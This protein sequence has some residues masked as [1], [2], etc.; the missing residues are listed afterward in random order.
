ME[1]RF[2][3]SLLSEF[4]ADY[5][6][7]IFALLLQPS[8]RCL[9]ICKEFPTKE[10]LHIHVFVLSAGGQNSGHSM[11]CSWAG[12]CMHMV[13]CLNLKPQFTLQ[14]KLRLLTSE[15][16]FC[17]ACTLLTHMLNSPKAT[18]FKMRVMQMFYI[19]YL[20]LIPNFPLTHGRVCAQAKGH[21]WPTYISTSKFNRS[22]ILLVPF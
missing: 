11:F 6:N 18:L 1:S 13:V 2:Q 19:Y 14:L 21:L 20:S 15:N 12:L 4:S 16:S 22:N 5:V 10:I 3:T 17:L 9:Q 7:S 8:D